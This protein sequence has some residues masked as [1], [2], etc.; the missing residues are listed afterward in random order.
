MNG[1]GTDLAWV[2]VAIGV[3]LSF[4]GLLSTLYF[5]R[6]DRALTGNWVMHGRANG[7][8]TIT[9]V[10]IWLTF[11][12]AS[13][14]VYGTNVWLSIISGLM[15]IWLLSLPILLWREAVRHEGIP[16]RNPTLP[17]TQDQRE[18]REFGEQRRSLEAEHLDD[19]AADL[20]RQP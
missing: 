3:L 4:G 12:R 5:M 14:L 11:A 7:V 17:E 19:A 13:T 9:I 16:E 20:E 18:D 8:R 15:I 6:L 10:A 2:T 1:I